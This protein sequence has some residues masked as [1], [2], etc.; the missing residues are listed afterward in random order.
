MHS[1]GDGELDAVT[2]PP[3]CLQGVRRW[4]GFARAEFFYIILSLTSK[5]LLAWI[6]FGGT[7]RFKD[8]Y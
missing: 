2:P 3:L 8:G 4:A 7:M 6:T 5:Q 1:A